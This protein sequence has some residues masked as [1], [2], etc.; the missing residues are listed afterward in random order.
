MLFRSSQAEHA[1]R[2]RR[3]YAPKL[4]W[5]V[6]RLKENGLA[7]PLAR[8]WCEIGC[9]AG[10]FLDALRQAGAGAF[11]GIEADQALAAR[12]ELL[13]TVTGDEKTGV[14]IIVKALEEPARQIAENAGL[15]GSVVVEKVKNLEAGVGYDAL[16]DKYVNMI[17]SGI[18]DPTKVTF[19]GIAVVRP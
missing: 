9:G 1:S 7:D 18:V 17:D 13:S 8:K 10:Y 12:A 2:V 15:E 5:I 4:E 11:Q 3:V 14:Q 19:H 6:R 16:N